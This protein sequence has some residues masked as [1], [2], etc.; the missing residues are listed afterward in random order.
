MDLF[1]Q[2]S[3]NSL[4][5]LVELR[6]GAKSEAL[7]RTAAVDILDRGLGK[8]LQRVEQTGPQSS[9]DPVAEMK[10]LEEDNQ[11]RRSALTVPE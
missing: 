4:I 2:E 9:S 3:F 5:T 10:R 11:R 6:T 8:P 1:R 7:R